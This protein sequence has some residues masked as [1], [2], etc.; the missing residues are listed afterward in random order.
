[1]P[2]TVNE[3]DRPSRLELDRYAT[4]ELQGAERAAVEERLDAR[5]RAHLDAVSAPP[6]PLDVQAVRARAEGLRA[7][8]TPP[9]ANRPLA[10]LAALVA[11][12]VVLFL[13]LPS[14]PEPA[15]DGLKGAAG[16]DLLEVRG[17]VATPWEG[18]PVPAG[19]ELAVQVRRGGHAGATV[20][21]VDG[22]GLVS[23]YWPA[24]GEQ[25][26][27][28]AEPVSRLGTVVLDDAAGPEVFVVA[29]DSPPAAV[30]V[31]VRRAWADGGLVGLRRWAEQA[32]ASIVEVPRR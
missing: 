18:A 31:A 26:E 12:A 6:P 30:E 15:W 8:H 3:G 29:Y 16:V 20:L 22:A 28:L 10:W 14:T 21:S 9:P 32:G 19:A 17:G 25:P 11:A 13:L 27:P 5:A 24:Q 4:G 7:A 2:L 23:R 1:M